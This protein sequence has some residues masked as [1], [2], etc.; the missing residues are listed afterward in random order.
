VTGTD[1][2]DEALDLGEHQ[3]KPFYVVDN[4]VPVPTRQQAADEMMY[5]INLT[6][7]EKLGYR[8]DIT[9]QMIRWSVASSKCLEL[10]LNSRLLVCL[11]TELI[12]SGMPAHEV[13]LRLGHADPGY[14]VNRHYRAG[15][16]FL[17]IN[18]L[19]DGRKVVSPT[20]LKP[21]ALRDMSSDWVRKDDDYVNKLIKSTSD[22]PLLRSDRNRLIYIRA[23]R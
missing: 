23:D 16:A 6:C 9:L 22:N 12:N 3:L 20:F 5:K 4:G 2:L 17:P 8:F 11:S 14:T 13:A 15:D 19:P 7:R 21:E 10:L 18:E 1:E